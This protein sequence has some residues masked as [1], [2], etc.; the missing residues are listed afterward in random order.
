[1]FISSIRTH[2]I[3]SVYVITNNNSFGECWGE[4]YASS[5]ISKTQ[6]NDRCAL[7]LNW[8]SKQK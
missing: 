5:G 8:V 6:P 4:R 3:V 7:G 2:R 1:M